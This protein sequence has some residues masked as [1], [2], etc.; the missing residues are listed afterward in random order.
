M[1]L[2]LAW[3]NIWRNKRRSMI[4]AASVTFALFFAIIMRSMQLGTYDNV[5]ENVINSSTGYV[6]VH[7]K[8]YWENRTLE[9]SFTLTDS[10]LASV[11]STEGVQ[12][13]IP[14]LES[15][16]LLSTGNDTKGA[17]IM[18]IDPEAETRY[19]NFGEGLKTG[20][21]ITADDRKMLFT[22]GLANYFD[23]QP[24]DTTITIGQG[25]HGINANALYPVKGIV[26]LKNPELNNN[27]AY[28]PIQEAQELFG[29]YNRITA[30][31][32][33][34]EDDDDYKTVKEDLVS[35]L[36]T[37]QYEVMTWREMMPELI[38]AMEADNA[39]GLVILFILYL[40]IGFGVFGT[41]LMLTTERIPEFGIL[42]SIGMSRK[43]IALITFMET[44]FLALIG[45]LMGVVLAMPITYYF[46]Y[47]PIVLTGGM[48]DAMLEYGFEPLMPTS[49][50][51]GIPLAHSIGVLAISM[52][53]S[54]YAVYKIY[55]LNPV[56]AMRT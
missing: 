38:Q 8:D 51:L 5:Y 24:E 44:T 6:Q 10:L 14:R 9:E 26:K 30:L 41:I 43:K 35:R 22:Q 31:V 52:L 16:S 28:L 29:A 27:L 54:L 7:G 56:K 19:F 25:Y 2:K 11:T 46:H 33:I 15:F 1:L 50:D 36:D 53:L 37:S 34:P 39:G 32:I 40:V 12:D 42:I 49:I 3:R 55:T 20:Q 45:L 48:N 17:M 18:G 47:N 23:L 13:A 4:T 21:L